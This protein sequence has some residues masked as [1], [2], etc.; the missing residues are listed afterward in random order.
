[1]TCNLFPAFPGF[2]CGRNGRLNPYWTI[3]GREG[4][5][6]TVSPTP[7]KAMRKLGNFLHA[8]GVRQ[9]FKWSSLIQAWAPSIVLSHLLLRGNIWMSAFFLLK[10]TL[11]KTYCLFPAVRTKGNMDVAPVGYK[12]LQFGE[13]TKLNKQKNPKPLPN[14]QTKPEM[15]NKKSFFFLEIATIVIIVMLIVTIRI[16]L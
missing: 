5:L 4:G 8:S 13:K 14:K 1:M 11:P 10:F 3:K 16:L 6:P 2:Y 12:T 7:Q 9:L 15:I